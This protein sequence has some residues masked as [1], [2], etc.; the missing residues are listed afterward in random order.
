MKDC[1][2]EQSTSVWLPPGFIGRVEVLSGASAPQGL[3]V[4]VWVPLPLPGVAAGWQPARPAAASAR[5]RV[6]TRTE[7]PSR[8]RRDVMISSPLPRVSRGAVCDARG[9]D[10]SGPARDAPF[11]E[12]TG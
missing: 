7:P 12:R 4:A 1:Q 10:G 6:A 11:S 3:T 8:R 9:G 2:A 5:L